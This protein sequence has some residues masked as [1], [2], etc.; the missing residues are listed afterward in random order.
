M[1]I[2]LK[3]G[4]ID[5]TSSLRRFPKVFGNKPVRFLDCIAVWNSSMEFVL[6]RRLQ[7]RFSSAWRGYCNRN[8]SGTQ[9]SSSGSSTTFAGG[10]QTPRMED[11]DVQAYHF[12]LSPLNIIRSLTITSCFSMTENKVAQWTIRAINDVRHENV[13]TEWFS[14]ELA[15]RL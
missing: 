12:E 6:N 11:H 9:L 1:I 4:W 13:T 10:I 8:F 7:G 2:S 14:A 5:F 15:C 3:Y